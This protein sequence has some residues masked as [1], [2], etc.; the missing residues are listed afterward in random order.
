MKTDY[1]KAYSALYQ[2]IKLCKFPKK[3]EELF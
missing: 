1:L 3:F 2:I